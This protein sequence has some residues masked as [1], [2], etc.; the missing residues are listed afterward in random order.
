V[1]AKNFQIEKT[2]LSG[3]RRFMQ[4]IVDAVGR[5]RLG[6]AIHFKNLTMFPVLNG[7]RILADYLVLDEA[8]AA[9]YARVTEVSETGS[10]PE[11]KF[12]NSCDKAVFLLDGEEL[13]GAKQNRVLNLSILAPAGKTVVI[14]VSC[15][16]A[17][18]WSHRSA[19]F[20]SA[21]RAQ[22]AGGRAK[23]MAQVTDSLRSEGCRTSNQREVWAD[24]DLKAARMQAHSPTDAMSAIYEAH[25]TNLEDFVRA[26][27]AT[28]NQAGALFAINEV[29]TGLDLFDC[30]ETLRKLFPKL[31]RSYALDAL[32]ALHQLPD[33]QAKPPIRERAEGFLGW[34]A[35]ARAETF[36]A[37]G[38]GEDVRL[39]ATCLTGAALVADGSV[40]HLSA[41]RSPGAI[42]SHDGEVRPSA[43]L[44]RPS[45]RRERRGTLSGD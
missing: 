13:V 33:T 25:Q 41:F 20:A 34:V 27:F 28:E 37:I 1:I 10:V 14:P 22:Y 7:G 16:E 5:L 12:V 8:L 30:S 40:I 17:G 32:D 26:F 4:L 3:E 35:S 11:L 42:E 39:T 23:K 29:I 15:V 31:V 2:P 18:R 6:E 36:P 19:A 21:P 9:G 44:S 24:I 38:Q 45:A 43:R